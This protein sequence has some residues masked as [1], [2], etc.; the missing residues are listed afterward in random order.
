MHTSKL[1]VLPADD[2]IALKDLR[3][4]GFDFDG[5]TKLLGSLGT[6]DLARLPSA[7]VAA[8]TAAQRRNF[9]VFVGA[10]RALSEAAREIGKQ[11]VELLRECAGDFAGAVKDMMVADSAEA[12]V[13]R[14]IDFTKRA[15]ANAARH[16]RESSAIASRSREHLLDAV[17]RGVAG[18]FDEL[19]EASSKAVGGPGKHR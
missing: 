5:A 15:M 3:L 7:V 2:P 19:R 16:L 18:A 6:A 13:R 11:Q 1:P 17:G 8:T 10:N 4:A 9:E 12:R 14:Q